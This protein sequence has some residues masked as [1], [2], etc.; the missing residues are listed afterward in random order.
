MSTF[1][2]AL[3][4]SLV[5]AGTAYP[6]EV[7]KHAN[8]SPAAPQ[9]SSPSGALDFQTDTFTGRFQYRFP[10]RVAPARNGSEPAISLVYDSGSG[11]GFCGVGWTLDLGTIQR[12]TRYGVPFLW[13]NG[14]ATSYDNSKGFVSS[15]Q[16]ANGRLVSIGNGEYRA[17][18]DRDF[19]T[20]TA[21]EADGWV[22]YD[23]SGT[24]FTFLPG[25]KN[26]RIQP[27]VDPFDAT[28]LWNLERVETA[29]GNLTRIE[30]T[31]HLEQRY[32]QKIWY[33]GHTNNFPYT[34]SIEFVWE[35]RSP[36]T[37]ISYAAGFRVTTIK[38]LKEIIA[39]VGQ[40]QVRKYILTYTTSP[41]TP[42]SLL[43]RID[44]HGSDATAAMPPVTFEYQEKETGFN[45]P[46]TWANFHLP[47]EGHDLLDEPALPL[48]PANYGWYRKL[49]DIDGDA[50]P[51]VVGRST[52]NHFSVRPSRS[53][54]MT[55]FGELHSQTLNWA[56]IYDTPPP[57]SETAPRSPVFV[58]WSGPDGYVTT[59]IDLLDINGDGYLDR[60]ARAPITSPL[61]NF[62]V[63]LGTGVGFD[64][65][66]AWGGLVIPTNSIPIAR[67]GC[68]TASDNVDQSARTYVTL[69][70]MNGDGLP[71]RVMRAPLPP[72]EFYSVQLNNGWDFDP[73]LTWTNVHRNGWSESFYGSVASP[74][75]A[76]IDLNGDGLP[77]RVLRKPSSPY[78]VW[79]VQFNNG[80]GFDPLENWGELE[81]GDGVSQSQANPDWLI[82]INCDGLP[83]KL[84]ENVEKVQLNTG[85]G[86]AIR[87][88]ITI[89]TESGTFWGPVFRDVNGDGILDFMFYDIVGDED[90][91]DEVRLGKGPYPDLLKTVRN[92]I[93]GTIE[94]TYRPSTHYDNRDR[95]WSGNPWAAGAK[96]LLPYV[97][98][99][100]ASVTVNGGLD[101]PQTTTYTYAN[102]FHDAATRE[103]RGFARS[104]VTDPLGTK[105]ITKFHQGGGRDFAAEGEYQDANSDAKKGT[106][107]CIETWG[108]D[109]KLYART[110]NK[111]EETVLHQNGWVFPYISQTI[112]TDFEPQP[113]GEQPFSRSRAKLFQYDPSNG[114]LTKQSDFG[115]VANV[116]VASH[117]FTD[118]QSDLVFAHTVYTNLNG[119]IHKPQYVRITADS[120]GTEP[121][122]LFERRFT[123]DDRTRSLRTEQVW[124]NTGPHFATTRSLTYNEFGNISRFTD[125]AGVFTDITSYDA[126]QVFPQ[127]QTTA[128][129]AASSQAFDARSGLPL[130]VTN[131]QGLVTRYTYDKLYRLTDR[132]ISI[133]PYQAANL[134]KESFEYSLDGTNG[135]QSFNYVKH[136]IND[137]TD[138]TGHES[139]A[140]SDGLG[141]TIR[142]VEEAEPDGAGNAR[143][144]VEDTFYD[145]RGQV[146]Y[147]SRPY[148][149]TL[150]NPGQRD[151]IKPRTRTQYD[152]VGRPSIIT[153]PPGDADSPTGP[154]TIV[155]LEGSNPWATITTDAKNTAKISRMDAYGRV[156]EIIEPEGAST[157][158]GYDLLGNLLVVI[159]SQDNSTFIDYD[160]LGRKISMYDRDMG[161]WYYFYDD[162]GRLTMQLDPN[163]KRIDYFYGDVLGRLIDKY[164]FTWNPVLNDWSLT[165]LILYDNDVSDDPAFT[166]YPGQQYRIWDNPGTER[167]SYDV[168]GRVLKKER[169]FYGSGETFLTE[170]SYDD[171]DRVTTITYPGNIAQVKYSYDTATHLKKVEALSSPVGPQVFYEATAFTELDKVSTIKWRNNSQTTTT[172]DYYPA[173]RRLS[174]IRTTRAGQVPIQDLTYKYDVVANVTSIHDAVNPAGPASDSLQNITYDD[175]HRLKSYA[176]D[177]QTNLFNY[178]PIGN[179][180]LNQEMGPGSYTY[181]QQGVQPHAVTSANGNVY[182]YDA[183]GNMIWRNGLN[184]A[185]DEE[186]RLRQVNS[187]F[188]LYNDG[189][190]RV[191]KLTLAGETV[192]IDDIYEREPGRTLCHVQAG[193]RRIVT[194]SADGSEFYYYHSDHLGSSSLITDQDGTLVRQQYG[195]RAFGSERFALSFSPSFTSRFTGQPYD[196]DTGLY[197]YQSRFYDPELG[198]FIQ[199]DSIVP[200]LGSSQSLNRYSYVLNN[201]LKYID[202][203]GHAEQKPSII[204]NSGTL[205]FG[206]GRNWLGTDWGSG[207]LGFGTGHDWLGLG[208]QAGGYR[209]SGFPLGMSDPYA[210]WDDTP[211]PIR[212]GNRSSLTYAE[213]WKYL[214]LQA[215]DETVKTAASVASMAI[216]FGGPLRLA[217]AAAAARGVARVAPLA[218]KGLGKYEVGSYNVLRE[219]AEAGLDAH[220]VGQK[221]LMRQFVKA[222]DPRTAPAILVP[223]FG[224]TAG[225]GVVSR[226]MRGVDSARDVLAR[227][228]REL[229]RVYPDIPNSQLK[230]LIEL[231]KQMY[232]EVRFKR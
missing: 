218:V 168:R 155:Y 43:T 181:N 126:N 169:Y 46:S 147:Q 56:P 107:F 30:Y 128:N 185:Y 113:A 119:R 173:S 6:A 201:P 217:R 145:A 129:Y 92:N 110:L 62:S 88:N 154:S 212:G 162:A 94:V 209:T 61:T 143:R 68:P 114:N 118:I 226:N 206:A 202:P 140:Y 130:S 44:E 63:R 12:E 9:P 101:A 117:S 60:V 77:D 83:D 91:P 24:K 79:R 112:A 16:G 25:L 159:D 220:H 55:N 144:R 207:F 102:G 75:A 29:D 87:R 22:V 124:I 152:P 166:V 74:G 42:R 11:N 198:R 157:L 54:G 32:P 172:Y 215:F 82:D 116:V 10:I 4:L 14:V 194:F 67:W 65:A 156:L 53:G 111:V 213:K 58:H 135:S 40:S 153:P 214:P 39:R 196:A 221:A 103:F 171:A 66:V 18:T 15:V 51:D 210:L 197:Y 224:H 19:L 59:I 89:Q 100:V 142:S 21:G 36:D 200:D 123:Y 109:G 7:Y 180:T 182:G 183:A 174:R 108:S 161:E 93:G 136:R 69:T 231:N 216:P 139:Y 186:N 95:A 122:R 47:A 177:G 27:P 199:P 20:F 35:N 33:N 86:F 146:E 188:Y 184:L 48:P 104:E 203:T 3:A 138:A 167:F 78:A 151:P 232:P 52:G 165:D 189:G 176:R 193:G 26:P 191:R 23:K 208:W 230:R 99:T 50:L 141:R 132:H 97:V 106:P 41:C 127:S 31:N 137:A 134:W 115:E 205:G 13:Q 222:Y 105:T 64:P 98:Q 49:V 120:A 70:D 121:W 8:T 38:R 57:P 192:W 175:L 85:T 160:S 2:R 34:H 71:D 17:A 28:F 179:I 190:E 149:A 158:Y 96:A 187:V 225:K 45:A 170:Y 76:L 1:I 80:A 37:N 164:L 73:P 211:G 150:T 84:F 195:Y 81:T 229:R 163:G 219:G 204:E 131:V 178:D 227:D 90:D 133:A 5:V 228:I 125:A 148:F 72:Y 223:Q